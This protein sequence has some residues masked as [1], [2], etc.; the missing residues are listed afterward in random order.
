MILLFLILVAIQKL[1]ERYIDDTTPVTPRINDW[2]EICPF[3]DIWL[4]VREDELRYV[5]DIIPTLSWRNGK[6]AFV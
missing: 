6:M 5:A 2:V 3:I 1:G 4:D